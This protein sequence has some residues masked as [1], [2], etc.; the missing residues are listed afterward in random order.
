MRRATDKYRAYR[1]ALD[2]FY[3]RPPCGGRPHQHFDHAAG[4][5]IS[6]HALRA[7]GD[8]RPTR[9]T[10]TPGIFLSTPSVRRATLLR[11][12]YA[13]E[14]PISIHALRAEGDGM[15]FRWP[16]RYCN[17]YPR[18]PCG[19][20]PAKRKSRNSPANF[21]PRPPCGGRPASWARGFSPAEF[22]STPSVRRATRITQKPPP[23]RS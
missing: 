11:I 14:F 16:G 12:F 18:P 13:D 8:S 19:G 2:N 10:S 9:T 22:L 20:R 15:L 7:E 6:I 3:P 21:Y 4:R 5:Q 17:F 23:F 1:G